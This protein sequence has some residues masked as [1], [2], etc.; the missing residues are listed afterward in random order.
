MHLPAMM[1]GC[2]NPRGV[3]MQ[4]TSVVFIENV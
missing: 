2:G 4:E 3:V 1:G